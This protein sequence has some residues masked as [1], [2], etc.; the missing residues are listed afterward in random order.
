MRLIGLILDISMI[1]ALFIGVTTHMFF[2]YESKNTGEFKLLRNRLRDKLPMTVLKSMAMAVGS[3]LVVYFL[4]LLGF[5]P[6]VFFLQ[7]GRGK[8]PPRPDTPALVLVHGLYHNCSAWFVFKWRLR[9]AGFRNV[10]AFNFSSFHTDFFEIRRNLESYVQDVARAHGPGKVFVVGHSLGGLLCRSLLATP[11]GRQ[12]VA[13]ATTW[14]APHCG[15]KLAA[16]AVGQ[17][18]RS[19]EYQGPLIKTIE[20]EDRR[21]D[22][23]CLNLY[24]PVDDFVL[25]AAGL[26]IRTPGWREVA[27]E[28]MSHIAMLFHPAPADATIDFLKSQRADG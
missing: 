22:C 3:Q 23:P 21:P 5:F 12:C 6:N 16:V 9:R 24:S 10:Y 17:L 15:S 8:T 7:P 4:Y 28:D 18:G 14:G 19:L 20:A 13:G 11:G 1:M 2:L 26:L 25:P 27:T